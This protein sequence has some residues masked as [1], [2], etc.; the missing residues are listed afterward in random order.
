MHNVES[1]AYRNEVIKTNGEH[2][3]YYAGAY[4]G[5]GLHEGAALSAF[6]VAGLIR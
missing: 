5:D 2:Q 6:S 1:F 4:L 3:T